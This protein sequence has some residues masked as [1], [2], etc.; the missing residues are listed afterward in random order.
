MSVNPVTSLTPQIG[1]ILSIMVYVTLPVG[2]ITDYQIRLIPDVALS[3]KWFKFRINLKRFYAVFCFKLLCK[4]QLVSYKPCFKDLISP[5]LWNLL[6]CHEYNI[7]TIT[8]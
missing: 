4:C 2:T 6:N 3:K 8:L 7:R 5:T 1:D